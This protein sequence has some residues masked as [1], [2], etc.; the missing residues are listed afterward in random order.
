MKIPE[1]VLIWLEEQNHGQITSAESVGGGCINNGARLR[2][3]GGSSFF[4][5][6]NNRAPDDMFQREAEGLKALK[7][8]NGPRVPT[9]LLFGKKYLL[10]EDLKPIRPIGDYWAIYG[11]KLANLHNQI[12][13]DFG[14]DHD[15]YIGSTPQINKWTKDGH[16]FFSDHRLTFQADLAE[17]GGYLEKQDCKGI[18]QVIRKLPD[19]IPTQ[20]ASL[21][22]G[23]LW[24]GNAITDGE[25]NPA[26]IDPAAH[27]GWAE[28]ELGMTKLF[29]GFPQEF[30][31][32]YNEERPLPGGWKERL[33]IYNLYHLLNHVNLFGF[34]YL[35]Q[36]RAIIRR[37]T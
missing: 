1:A 15:N 27:Y 14:F 30:Y 21:L 5:K 10:L 23:D 29:G 34:G 17:Q 22:H 2:T 26:M 31:R 28:A 20:P 35:G 24:S 36:V 9:P 4:I 25:G 33:S 32:S 18:E 19:L 16:E 37:F 13:A 11:R 3:D 8:K 6:Q 7:I 12:N